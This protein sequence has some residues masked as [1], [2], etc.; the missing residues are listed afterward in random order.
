M[1]LGRLAKDRDVFIDGG[2]IPDDED[3]LI[4]MAPLAA[5]LGGYVSQV[6]PCHYGT[7]AQDI[8]WVVKIAFAE[9]PVGS[10]EPLELDV[11]CMRRTQMLMA[12]YE[13]HAFLD[14]HTQASFLRAVLRRV[15]V[16][17]NAIGASPV[18]TDSLLMWKHDALAQRLVVQRARWAEDG[19]RIAK[20]LARM[21]GVGGKYEGWA[22]RYEGESGDLVE[23]PLGATQLL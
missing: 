21:T 13:P 16:R 19:D 18:G 20:R 22:V 5:G 4:Y 10:I 7:W 15:D 8:K 17:L 1:A 11:V 14:P 9:R 2:Y 3:P 23:A 12:G 6:I